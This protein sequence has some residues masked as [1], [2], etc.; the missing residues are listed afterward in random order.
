MKIFRQSLFL[1]PGTRI[2]YRD[3]GRG[4]QPIN[5]FV[6]DDVAFIDGP[7]HR[8][9]RPRYIIQRLLNLESRLASAE[10]DSRVKL[11]VN[12]MALLSFTI[13][14]STGL[15]ICLLTSYH[16]C[17]SLLTKLEQIPQRCRNSRMHMLVVLSKLKS[18]HTWYPCNHH[19]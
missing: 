13:H 7:Y 8:Q 4:V 9:Q 12:P 2:H 1:E 6:R 3:W 15:V 5:S 10:K 16:P 18:E 14:L 19:C 17:L 11:P